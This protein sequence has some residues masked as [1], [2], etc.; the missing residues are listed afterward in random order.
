MLT[1]EML[2]APDTIH[3]PVTPTE[4]HVIHVDV[5]KFFRDRFVAHDTVATIEKEYY[6]GGARPLVETEAS[7]PEYLARFMSTIAAFHAAV[8]APIT[9]TWKGP[10]VYRV[11][12]EYGLSQSQDWDKLDDILVTA[13]RIRDLPY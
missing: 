10:G 2:E 7:N 3:A 12:V 8:R 5:D 9:E 1:K 6:S 13:K 11:A 4:C